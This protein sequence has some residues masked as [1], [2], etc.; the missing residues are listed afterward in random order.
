MLDTPGHVQFSDEAFSAMRVSD[1]IILVV[2]AAEGITFES[3]YEIVIRQALKEGLGIVLCLSKMDR[4]IVEQRLPPRSCYSKISFIITQLNT[5]IHNQAISLY[6]D[7][8]AYIRGAGLPPSGVPHPILSP[9][10]GNVIF[11]SSAHE[12]MFTLPSFLS[13]YQDHNSAAAQ[14]SL[15]DLV[16]RMWGEWYYE[17]ATSTITR[18]RG[19]ASLNFLL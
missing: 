3:M 9:V 8:P 18:E 6:K 1:G 4:L 5:I 7:T 14:T 13:F 11:C 19:M 15:D 16:Q 17:A 10:L 12:Y 2:D